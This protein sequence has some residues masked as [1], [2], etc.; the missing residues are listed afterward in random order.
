MSHF[1]RTGRFVGLSFALLAGVLL[2]AN[3]AEAQG[4]GHRGGGGGRGGSR[5]VVVPGYGGFYGLGPM[6]WSPFYSEAYWSLYGPGAYR[7]AGGVDMNV[8]MMAG[9]GAIELNVKPNRADVWVDG[10]YVGEAR[11]LDGYPSY[12]WL[13]R[14]AHRVAVYKGGFKTFEED[15]EVDRGMKKDLRIRMEAGESSPPPGPKPSD[16]KDERKSG[17]PH[18]KGGSV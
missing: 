10:K 4:R 3:G 6:W 2:A 18:A 17:A 13:E 8:A 14:G 15:V 1:R 12:L 7:A 16:R 9:W 5:V 11:D